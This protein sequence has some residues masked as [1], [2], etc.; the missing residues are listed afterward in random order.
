MNHLS[1]SA[2]VQE[3]AAVDDRIEEMQSLA[4][5]IHHE[6]NVG[7]PAA[8]GEAEQQLEE[9]RECRRL[10]ASRVSP[11]QVIP[12]EIWVDIWTRADV[13]PRPL[14]SPPTP[15]ALSWV[16][17]WWRYV[18][19]RTPAMWDFIQV[20]PN[21]SPALLRLQVQRSGSRL[22]TILLSLKSAVPPKDGAGRFISLMAELEKC[23]DRWQSFHL[24]E[25]TRP[26]GLER[27][28]PALY[29]NAAL[30]FNALQ[31]SLCGVHV[32]HLR[33]F[34]AWWHG[35]HRLGAVLKRGAPHLS[36]VQLS[37]V[38]ISDN[39][40]LLRGLTSLELTEPHYRGTLTKIQL[41][42]TLA[43][44]PA[45]HHLGLEG[46]WFE[47]D[48]AFRLRH[49]DPL[50][51]ASLKSL[52]LCMQDRWEEE[53]SIVHDLF[54]VVI[55]PRLQS[56][57]LVSLSSQTC[58]AFLDVLEQRPQACGSDS[59]ALLCLQGGDDFDKMELDVRVYSRMF[60][61]FRKLR[62]LWI[63][64]AP[65]DASSCLRTLETMADGGT[66]LVPSLDTLTINVGS[67]EDNGADV[68]HFIAR[69]QEMGVPIAT[70]RVYPADD[71]YD[72][73][74]LEWVR[75][76]QERAAVEGITCHEVGFDCIETLENMVFAPLK[77]N[78]DRLRRRPRTPLG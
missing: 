60:Q 11:A 59:L 75:W 37:N 24:R 57:Q 2:H 32:P 40:H 65:E 10:L 54:D 23:A 41:R 26:K 6:T 72:E 7:G 44:C 31:N 27:S 8:R 14:D 25:V 53:G 78:L 43:A 13:V 58:D 47:S 28:D 5:R 29:S 73:E 64:T 61:T 66:P 55:A 70:V 48:P 69:R 30:Y 77:L 49:P 50:A 19:L 76:C 33:H 56:L 34:C 38:R 46:R 4:S 51:L 18:L 68:P 1:N 36:E 17:K 3:L 52:K 9:L 74:I 15:F 45:L 20:S 21:T 22:L 42:N 12:E 39:L 67:A 71:V 16:S 62:H 35:E 63:D